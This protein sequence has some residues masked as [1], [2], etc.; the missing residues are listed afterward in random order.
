M[1]KYYFLLMISGMLI[2]ACNKDYTTAEQLPE[3][4]KEIVE[5]DGYYTS[6][7]VYNQN[8]YHIDLP[9]AEAVDS[10]MSKPVVI[11][12]INSLKFKA[13][14][15][16]AWAYIKNYEQNADGIVTTHYYMH[17][18]FKFNDE[19]SVPVFF[20]LD[21]AEIDGNNMPSIYPEV[22]ILP[23]ELKLIDEVADQ[24]KGTL[25][26]SYLLTCS[27]RISS[28]GI[29]SVSTTSQEL[30]EILYEMRI[31]PGIN[32]WQDVNVNV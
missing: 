25:T 5:H 17:Y 27:M 31:E 28:N 4:K 1:K 16:K 23:P 22:E 29:S 32:S 19:L 7:L 30:H 9:Y 18:S 6:S 14:S 20:T 2:T 13:V 12:D 15:N 10:V 21:R 26:K 24:E 3:G 11:A 8:T